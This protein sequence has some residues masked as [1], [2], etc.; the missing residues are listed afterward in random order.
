MTVQ[1]ANTVSMTVTYS[2]RQS[3]GAA[4]ESFESFLETGGLKSTDVQR[5]ESQSSVSEKQKGGEIDA[6]ETAGKTSANAAED[7]M[8]S[9]NVKETVDSTETDVTVTNQ[10]VTEV[11]LPEEKELT[12][13]ILAEILSVLNEFVSVLQNELQIT[14]QQLSDVAGEIQFGLTDFFDADRMKEL[15]LHVNQV[16][17]S[18]LLTDE[19]LYKSLELLQNTLSE[20]LENSEL[21]QL[22]QQDGFEPEQFDMSAFASQISEFALEKAMPEAI[23]ETVETVETVIEFD[24]EWLKLDNAGSET[25]QTSA[26]G[27]GANM[28]DVISEK[29]GGTDGDTMNQS[30]DSERGQEQAGLFLQ[31]LVSAAVKESATESIQN[32]SA[33]FELYD[34]ASQIIDQV[35]LQIRPDNAKMEIQLNP[36]HLGKVELEVSSKNGELSARLNVQN[37]LVKEAVESQ[38]QILRDTLEAQGLKVENIEV[39]V[40]EFG[41]RF[42]DEQ[43]S[44]EQFQQEQH[45]RNSLQFDETD[46]EEQSFSDVSEVMKELNGNSVDYVA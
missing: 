37:D 41:F 5:T 28:V 14:E 36:E 29:E 45:R 9:G 8:T 19:N 46:S 34:I 39:T 44:A 1:I 3:S 35:K 42:Q 17:A 38:M 2:S 12:E 32:V 16:E 6:Q 15:F 10:E 40:A 27:T 31:K 23:V 21:Y 22:L 25:V 4:S 11:E 7:E 43:G 18:E 26:T 33:G 13:D 24:N 30:F 20:V